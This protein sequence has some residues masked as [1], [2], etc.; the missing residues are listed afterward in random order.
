MEVPPD[1]LSRGQSLL[2]NDFRLLELDERERLREAVLSDAR[3]FPLGAEFQQACERRIE[4]ST[5]VMVGAERVRRLSK[6]PC[7][8]LLFFDPESPEFLW[9]SFVSN[10]ALLWSRVELEASALERWKQS[11]LLGD[12]TPVSQRK[13]YR[14]VR[15]L[16]LEN[17][18]PIE[19]ALEQ[20]ETWMDDARWSSFH[21]DD[22]WENVSR[23]VGMMR[24]HAA[25]EDAEKEHPGRFPTVSARTLWSGGVLRVEQYHYGVW[26]FE[27][28]YSPAPDHAVIEAVNAAIGLDLPL[29]VPVDLAS[30][31]LRGDSI[32]AANL[33]QDSDN[34]IHDAIFRCVLRP[35]EMTS[36]AALRA[37]IFG[38]SDPAIQRELV[39]IASQF[40]MD[41]LLSEVALLTKDAD[42]R[43]SLLAHLQ[44]KPFEEA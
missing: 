17:R 10:P 38:A 12:T 4:R 18:E 31:V 36:F 8:Q 29:D 20:V 14:S 15:I 35:G 34:P 43:A 6:L 33:E 11:Y 2:S 16:G 3:R 39:G 22:P 30:S 19:A 24:L 44:P 13:S 27:L 1:L 28:R 37:A 32:L 21:V 5:P 25:R 23:Q 42:L 26:A 7:F 9:A 41:G 40:G